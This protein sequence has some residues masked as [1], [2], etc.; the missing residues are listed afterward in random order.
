MIDKSPQAVFDKIV[1]HLRQQEE[2]STTQRAGCAYRG[3]E[4]R[5]CAAGCLIPDSEYSE[6]MEGVMSHNLVFFQDWP[7]ATKRLIS[8]LQ[9]LHDRGVL[10]WE[11]GFGHIANEHKLNLT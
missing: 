3:V 5:S 4:G 7:P 11:P 9:N 10:Y 6:S 1:A 2:L 8:D